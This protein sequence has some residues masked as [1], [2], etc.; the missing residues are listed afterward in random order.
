MC[1]GAATSSG[2]KGWK[3]LTSRPTAHPLFFLHFSQYSLGVQHPFLSVWP[4]IA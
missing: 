3:A 4:L 2:A 1:C